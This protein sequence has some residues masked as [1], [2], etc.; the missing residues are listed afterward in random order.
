MAGHDQGGRGVRRRL[1]AAS[2]AGRA[3][4]RSRAAHG[5]VREAGDV[6][7]VGIDLAWGERAPSGLA[8]L[9]ATG[10]LVH[11]S[12]ASTDDTIVEALGDYVTGACLVGI[13]APLIVTNATG[14]RPCEAALNQDF[15]RFDAGTHPSNTGKPEFRGVPRGAR[16]AS[17]LGL[18]ID[19][20]SRSDRRAIEVCPHA[21]LVALFR[22]GRTLKYKQRS[23]RPFPLVHAETLRLV[24]LL[25]GLEHAVPP[26]HVA[27][28][29]EW[30]AL[31]AGVA[32]A[33]R[34]SDLRRAE[35]QLDAVVCA[36]VALLAAEHPGATTTYGDTDTGY[37]VTPTLPSDLSPSPR[38]P[39]RA[40]EAA[41][42]ATGSAE[43]V[44]AE[45]GPAEREVDPANIVGQAVRAIRAGPAADRG[46]G[47]AARALADHRAGRRGDRLPERSPGAA[48][49]SRRSRRRRAGPWPGNCSIRIR[50][51]TS[52]SRSALGSSR[53]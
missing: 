26:L 12:R 31:V 51:A 6:N 36:Y 22:L 14:N 3:A 2:R 48:R 27:R 24:S 50:C 23:T 53:T 43:S 35:D 5:S 45:V 19:P 41:A 18:D 8:V 49:G 7:F 40:G 38:R 47:A 16:L 1:A 44:S 15:A 13:D 46:V 28:S 4:C 11:L 29:A 30:E 9:D 32:R 52:P 37:I 39:L 25:A 17:R 34:K 10:A 20:A 42:E 21:A 33:G